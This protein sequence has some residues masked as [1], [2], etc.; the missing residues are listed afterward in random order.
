MQLIQQTLEAIA[1]Y[2]ARK[3]K[4][5]AVLMVPRCVSG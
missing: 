1:K 5:W 4:V 3:D 2:E